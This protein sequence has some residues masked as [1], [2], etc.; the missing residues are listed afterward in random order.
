MDAGENTAVASETDEQ[1]H[2]PIL[3]GIRALVGVAGRSMAAI[4]NDV[5]LPQYR[6]LVV[7]GRHGPQTMSVLAERLGLDPSTLTRSCDR[8]VEK[9]LIRRTTDENDRRIVVVDLT[10]RSRRLIDQVTRRRIAEIDRILGRMTPAARRRL[11]VALG[12]LAAAAEGFADAAWTL[13][14][15]DAP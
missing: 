9:K 7:I 15:S 11:A 13:G 10:A 14:W 4:T 12:E 1:L 8:L 5:S 6:I 3:E 2:E